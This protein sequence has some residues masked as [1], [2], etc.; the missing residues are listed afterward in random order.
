MR[1]ISDEELEHW[2]THGYVLIEHLLDEEEL[3]AARENIARYLPTWEEYHRAPDR[4]R[5][6]LASTNNWPMRAFPF[7]GMA[8]NDLCT[9]PVL[10]S[11]ARQLL[12]TDNVALSHSR[13][14]GKYA[15]TGN[16]DQDLHVDYNNNTLAYPNEDSHIL[17]LPCIIYYTDVTV[18][19]GPTYVVS[20]QHTRGQVLVP[21]SRPRKEYPELYLHEVPAVLP[22]GSAVLYSMRTFHR[23]SAM[24]ASEGVRFSHHMS[25]RNGDCR[26]TGQG[27]FQ[28]DGGTAEMNQFIEQATPEQRSV[29]G[30][31]P[32]GHPYWTDDTLAGV[33]ARYPGMDLTPYR[34][35]MRQ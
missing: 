34:A 33:G 8:L 20:Q 24:T 25:W 7:A 6:L 30:F 23:G 11:L 2:R 14:R 1:A 15:G 27:T 26:W 31:P 5:S 22:A 32:V 17:D 35:A 29:V 19:L 13:L 12:G 4:Y 3:K 10:I 21:T 9:H 18:E 28:H 16:F